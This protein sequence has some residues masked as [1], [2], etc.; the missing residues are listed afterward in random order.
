VAAATA[1]TVSTGATAGTDLSAPQHRLTELDSGVRV[2][3][4][5]LPSVRS[6]ALGFWV[7]TGSRNETVA[8]AGISHFLEHLLFKGTDRFSS[9]E[10]DEI[11]DGMGAEINAGTGKETTSVY[12]RFLDQHLDRAFD[13]MADMVLRPSYPEID[14]ERQVVI[15]EIAMYEDEPSDK[16]HD[17][18][19]G[20]VFGDH[21]LGRPVIGRADVIASVP[22]PDIARYHDLRYSAS[23]LVLA[24]AGNID[25]DRLVSL[26]EAAQGEVPSAENGHL[27]PPAAVEARRLFHQK[28]TEQYHLCVG[29]PGLSRHDERRFV[30]RVLDTI[31][32]GS[33]SSR[34][35]QEVREKRGLAYAVYS[36]QSHYVDSGQ[37][38]VYVG[39][40]P[41]NVQEVFEIVGRELERIRTE[42]VSAEELDRA[43]ENV[44]GRTV[45][46]MESPLARMNRLGSSLL[47]G[48]PLLTL[49]ETLAK[50]DAVALDDVADL[51]AELLAAERLCAAGV[52]GDEDVFRDAVGAVSPA[53]AAA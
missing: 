29:A 36:Y 49:D 1:A 32:G 21:P 17:V 25:H 51:A 41:E 38:A 22:V 19:A 15:E 12:S 10:I 13:V 28:E 34:L 35:F 43:K 37:T 20:A 4:E 53:L 40:R 42:P 31:L 27:E 30:L 14:S 2:V 46:S 45:L 23:N 6:I 33:T 16:V 5:E 44:K 8:Q 52:G 3:T 24:A 39:T 9:T 11:F 48:V 18:L 50:I 47:M 7:R 26:I